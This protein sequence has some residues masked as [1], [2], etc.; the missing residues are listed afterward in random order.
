MVAHFAL[1]EALLGAMLFTGTPVLPHRTGPAPSDTSLASLYAAREKAW[2]DFFG[3]PDGLGRAL[4]G[5]FVAIHGGDSTWVDRLTTLK[6]SQ[7]SVA[8]GAR[9][10]SLT[11]PRN[12]VERYGNVAVIHSRYEAVLQGGGRNTIRGNIT[13]VF[14]WNG[15]SW[16][17]PSWHMDFDPEPEAR[18]ASHAPPERRLAQGDTA[19]VRKATA[20]YEAHHQEFDYLLG[21]WEFAGTRQWNNAVVPI[22]GFWSAN[23]SA[24]GAL[25]TDEFRMVDEGGRTLYVSTT[26]R[27]YNPVTERWNLIG[28]EPRAGIPQL[29]TAWKEGNDIRIDQTFSGQDGVSRLWRIRYYNIQGDRF[30]W[31]ADISSDGGKTWAE[32]QMTMEGRRTGPARSPVALTPRRET[33]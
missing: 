27:V 3:D 32:N 10:V 15:S 4:P 19:G 13:E 28:V 12:Q 5:S 16:S 25:V 6:Q 11:F 21:D 22:R 20:A 30:S 18:S 1:T 17:H 26:L 23:R 14:V 2:R 7:A 8:S 24:D 33:H 9:L 31:R 29:G